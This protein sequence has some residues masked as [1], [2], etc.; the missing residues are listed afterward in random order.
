MTQSN[1]ATQPLESLGA[2]LFTAYADFAASA[3]VQYADT[4]TRY[5]EQDNDIMQSRIMYLNKEDDLVEDTAATNTRIAHGFFPELVD[6]KVQYILGDE[7][8]EVHSK[9]DDS[10]LD[11]YLAPYFTDDWQLTMQE[12]VEGASIKG[13]EGLFARTT[14]DGTLRFQVADGTKL[15]PVFDDFG[16]LVRVLRYYTESRYSTEKQ[17]AI[18]VEHCDVWGAEGVAYYIQDAEGEATAFKLDPE[19]EINP[20]D[21]IQAEI[22]N[23]EFDPDIMDEADHWLPLGRNYSA[24]PFHILNNNRRATSDLQPIKGLIDDY[25]VMNCFLS[26]NLQDMAEAFYVIKGGEG[27]DIAAL[28]KN[29]KARKAIKVRDVDGAG[30]DVKTYNIPVEGRKVKMELDEVN[31]YRSGMGFNS[32]QLGDGNITNVII[33]S[34]YTLL[35]MKASKLIARLK[36]CLKWQAELVIADINLAH[37]TSYTADDICFEI[38]P[39]AI[40]NE[41][42][43]VKDKQIEQQTKQLEV[44]TIL[45]AAPRIGDDMT[46]EL[47]CESLDIDFDEVQK[48]LEEEEQAAPNDVV[49][50]PTA[51]L[52]QNNEASAA[53]AAQTAQ[54]QPTVDPATGLPVD[55]NV[56]ATT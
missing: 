28:K 25:D 13:F 24:F 31:I 39:K 26:N 19:I 41:S 12:L 4:A 36:S 27:E 56:S 32:Q 11:E 50:D 38:E 48:K 42:D 17:K 1:L 44:Q 23:P 3:P 40:V 52:P 35:D 20:A 6:Q 5:Y 9:D 14:A 47:I 46:L 22:E 55:P 34:R 37:S 54:Q 29:I 8:I 18:K 21:H 51:F 49:T 15:V 10:T 53:K 2:L 45:Q 16:A 43:I 33:K 30:V 7:G